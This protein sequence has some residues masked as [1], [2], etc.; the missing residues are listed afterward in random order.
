MAQ[1]TEQFIQNI[2]NVDVFLKRYK[3]I[4]HG[5]YIVSFQSFLIFVAIK[6]E[7]NI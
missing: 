5:M 3:D 7:T 6:E 1:N 4:W 2:N